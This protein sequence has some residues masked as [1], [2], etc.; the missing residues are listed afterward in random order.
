MYHNIPDV[1]K[2]CSECEQI[3]SIA[4]FHKS[5]IKKCGL[6]SRCNSFL[7]AIKDNPNSLL[8]YFKSGS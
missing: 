5:S 3:K 8:E 7:G 4:E 1:M 6:Q 2:R